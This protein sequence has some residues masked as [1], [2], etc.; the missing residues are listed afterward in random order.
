MCS[1]E[2]K[3]ESSQH[4]GHAAMKGLPAGETHFKLSIIS[5]DFEGLTTIKRH[6][7]VYKVG[8]GRSNQEILNSLNICLISATLVNEVSAYLLQ[9]D[10]QLAFDF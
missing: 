3:D 10:F 2:L 4:A 8:A 6:R 9:L 7:L 1:F 5:P